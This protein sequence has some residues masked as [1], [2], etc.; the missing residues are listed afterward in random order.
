M[1][2]LIV[3]DF[4]SLDRTINYIEHVKESIEH[5]GKFYAVIVDNSPEMKDISLMKNRFGNYITE[6]VCNK[7]V[8]VFSCEE[9]EI[10]Y[11]YSGENLG[12]AKGNNL[13]TKIVDEKWGLDFYLI[14]NND[15]EI[16]NRIDWKDIKKEFE[17]KPE[18]AVIGPRVIGL[19]GKNQSPQ[20]KPGVFGLLFFKY[21]NA[22][23][24]KYSKWSPDLDYSNE[25]KYCYRVM[26]SFLFIR[27]TNF[28]E[29]D[30]FDSHTFM[31]A[32]EIIL[33]EKLNK[34]NKKVYFDNDINVIHAHGETVNKT[35]SVVRGLYWSFESTLYYFEKYR[36]IPSIITKLAKINFTL[37]IQLYQFKQKIKK[38]MI[39]NKK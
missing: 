34:I 5:S 1:F 22:L 18:V 6:R 28:I 33:S 19:D 14:S 9:R 30:R 27:S 4:C 17:N 26:G 35:T 10:V 20:K 36:N 8:F 12:Y 29:V 3:V 2:A 39:E 24:G 31:Y 16:R 21:W 32:E 7:K 38:I 15:I 13:G 11:C 25:S 37:Y 23:L